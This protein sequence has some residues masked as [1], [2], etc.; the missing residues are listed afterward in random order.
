MSTR[1]KR[2]REPQEGI[3]ARDDYG[4][5]PRVSLLQ[6]V[7]TRVE[8]QSPHISPLEV[9]S[10]FADEHISGDYFHT[11]TPETI[12]GHIALISAA[13]LLLD[14]ATAGSP[15]HLE[16]EQSPTTSAPEA[17]EEGDGGCSDVESSDVETMRHDSHA[18]LQPALPSPKVCVM[19]PRAGPAATKAKQ[20]RRLVWTHE[21]HRRF[22]EAVAKLGSESARARTRGRGG[23]GG[24]EVKPRLT[25]LPLPLPP[26]RRKATG[27][28]TAHERGGDHHPEY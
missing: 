13:R 8:L 25:R 5:G 27:H 16:G 28:S 12:A 17:S 15:S 4:C 2:S 20:T 21:L 18:E 24:R 1:I 7:L 26:S 11:N 22:E 23:F 14:V 10:F 3:D 19:V 9:H 6:D